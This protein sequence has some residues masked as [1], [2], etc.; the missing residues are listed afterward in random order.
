MVD[1]DARLRGAFVLEPVSGG[2][3]AP[4]AHDD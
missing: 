4:T 3:P 1:A 2:G